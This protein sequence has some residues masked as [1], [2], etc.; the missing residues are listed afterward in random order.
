MQKQL[1]EALGHRAQAKLC[2]SREPLL[3]GTGFP[4]QCTMCLHPP[5]VG[6][7]GGLLSS[8]DAFSLAHQTRVLALG[9]NGISARCQ[10]GNGLPERDDVIVLL[11]KGKAPLPVRAEA[12][13][14]GSSHAWAGCVSRKASVLQESQS[15]SEPRE[16]GGLGMLRSCWSSKS[17]RSLI[18]W[19]VVFPF[20]L[21]IFNAE[22][23]Q[24]CSKL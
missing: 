24:N 14:R 21:F 16:L 15:Q 9:R 19:K 1:E 18:A 17:A 5:E 12:L 4:G 3:S 23:A 8:R 22:S 10:P 13:Q 6:R 7:E 11:S 2:S 20:P